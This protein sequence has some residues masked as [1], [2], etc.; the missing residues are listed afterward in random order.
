MSLHSYVV[1]SAAD[2]SGH[3][4]LR[5]AIL[6]A[7]AHPGTTITFAA[8]LAHHTIALSHELPLILGNH[9]V[10]N[11]SGAPHLSISGADKYR[12]FFVGDTTD[13]VSATIENLTISHAL[14]KGGD[15]GGAEF[16]GGGGA[17]LG[18]AIFVSSHASLAISGL[19][20]SDNAANGGDGGAAGTGTAGGGGGMGGN[21]GS[22]TV[23]PA[24]GGGFG[25]GADGGDGAL[26]GSSGKAGQFTNGAAGGNASSGVGT[27]GGASGG[28]GAGSAS[29]A[30]AGGG[31]GA[32]GSNANTS[33]GGGGGFG[34]GG[35]AGFTGAPGGFGGGGGAGLSSGNGG[36]GGGG[37][38][39]FLAA[40]SEGFGGRPGSSG[41]PGAGGGG[42]GMGGAIFVMDGGSLTA[43]G[44]FTVAGDTIAPG[45]GFG[46]FAS[47]FGA[48]LFLNGNGTIRFSPGP[49]QSEHVANAI[50]DEAGVVTSGY[51]P[52]LG[53][54]PGS[55]N[56]VKSGLGTLILSADNA[57]SGAITVA[58]GTLTVNGSIVHSATTVDAHATLAGTGTTGSVT[59]LGHGILSP[60][61]AK[62]GILNT[63]N[64]VL[65]PHAQFL[66]QLGGASPGLHG[67]DQL[68]VAGTVSLA[69][70]KLDLSLLGAVHGHSGETFEIINNDGI[71]P[72]IGHFAG[73]R[74]GAHLV[75]GG[76]VFSISYHGGDGNDVVLTEHGNAVVHAVH[77]MSATTVGDWLF[78]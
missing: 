16:G 7:N 53:F 10:I 11:G 62:A 48:G 24:G 52:P 26:N 1:T 61:G 29:D 55:Y 70:A 15:G 44:T 18:G 35:G 68:D 51:T 75:A 17:G 57:Y 32:G 22:G 27:T 21:G 76:K 19:V 50:D 45:S 56:L 39:G 38:A 63:G 69:G 64:V 20:L 49:G 71:D 73:L 46:G 6:Y 65:A 33:I 34:G 66:V 43:R 28:G 58:A 13:T 8:K 5:S 9:T 72:V 74:E 54:T 60:N 25:R 14:A 37:G 23:H 40:G 47:T 42:A 2:T 67:Y 31:G 4:T 12:V 30:T 77:H 78:A 41:G 36:F 59:V 3:G